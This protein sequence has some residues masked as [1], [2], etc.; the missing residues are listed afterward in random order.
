MTVTHTLKTP[1][2][3]NGVTYEELTFR[4]P[5][6]G[7]LVLMDGFQGEMAKTL[8]L[9]ASISEVPLP[10]FKMIE[11]DDFQELQLKI[12]PLLGNSPAATV[13]PTS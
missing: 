10:A 13:G 11:L 1:V 2:S 6:T 8:A 9:L 4:K 12:A 7:D 5:R 3:H